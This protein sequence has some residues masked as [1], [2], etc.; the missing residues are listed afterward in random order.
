MVISIALL[1]FGA[2]GTFLSLN[3]E[4]LLKNSD[5]LLPML[6]IAS[7]ISMVFAVRFSQ[8][9]SIQFDTYLLFSETSQIWSLILIYI[10]FIIPFF[11][12]SLAIAILFVKYSAS[13]GKLYFFNLI[14]SGVG[15]ILTIVLMWIIYPSTL[16]IVISIIPLIAG[17]F[18]IKLPIRIPTYAIL[19][20]AITSI[21][22]NFIYPQSIIS[23]QFKDISRTMNLTDAKSVEK[24]N[25]PYGFI[26]LVES[27]ALRFA[28]SVSLN[29]KGK[30]NPVEGLFNNGDWFG[31]VFSNYN[32]SDYAFLDYTT[33]SLPYNIWNIKN[34]LILKSGTGYRA[35][36]AISKGV[37]NVSAVESNSAAI[38][39]LLENNKLSLNKVNLHV[40]T[41]RS[42]FQSNSS[43]FD[44][45]AFP[46]IGNFGGN[47]G[48]CALQEDYDLTT[49]SF[50]HAW[51]ALGDN[52]VLTISSWIDYPTRKSLKIL[53]TLFDILKGSGIT[54]PSQHLCT[55]QSWN[56]VAFIVRKMVLT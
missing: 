53:N 28:P 44:L 20:I 33:E 39:F 42:F 45:I 34:A 8:L 6:M 9:E 32:D 56:T 25:S 1:G 19:I 29:F 3:K 23:S 37:E 5:L 24:R 50:Q 47:S 46:T 51:N 18:L 48:L 41:M 10:I 38:S 27:P 7:S 15:G 17:I 31:Q 16:P 30:L 35:L 43:K 21:G 11:L 26:E 22:F 13:I 14:G 54:E 36:Y 40:K 12:S 49:Q 52:G 2:S 4:R 55:I